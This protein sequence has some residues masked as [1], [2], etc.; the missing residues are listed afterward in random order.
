MVRLIPTD[1]RFF[2]LF[3]QLAER[4]TTA[5]R[6][7]A[8]LFAAPAR[9]AQLADEIKEVEHDADRVTHEINERIDKSFVT[10]FD[11]EDIH[12]LAMRLDN[13]IDLV[14]GTAR[15][16]VIFRITGVR[17]DAG[18]MA[19]VLLRSSRELEQLVQNLRR[20]REVL[21]GAPNVKRLEEEGDALYHDAVETLFRGHPDPLE[22]LKWKELYDR[23]EDAVDECAHAATTLESIALKNA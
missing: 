21:E 1:E 4:L 6:L 14:D 10:P 13:V 3:T 17:E 8:E 23:I 20:P 22:V 7:L 5:S 12:A 2:E 11:R 9:V 18:Q 16:A 19:D 15:R